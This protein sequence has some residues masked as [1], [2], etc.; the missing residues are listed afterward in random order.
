MSS[1]PMQSLLYCP[2]LLGGIWRT[3]PDFS[4][5]SSL[6]RAS[7]LLRWQVNHVSAENS[8]QWGGELVFGVSTYGK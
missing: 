1:S 7:I 6:M 5:A 8:V 2:V 3:V 4:I